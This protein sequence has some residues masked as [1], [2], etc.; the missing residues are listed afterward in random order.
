M[1]DCNN[2][3]HTEIISAGGGSDTLMFRKLHS[4]TTVALGKVGCTELEPPSHTLNLTAIFFV[5]GGCQ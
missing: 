3:W 5:Q 1:T 2:G 4:V